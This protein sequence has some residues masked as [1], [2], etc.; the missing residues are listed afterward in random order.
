MSPTLNGSLD[1]Q[2]FER[3]DAIEICNGIIF[4]FYTRL[5]LWATCTNVNPLHHLPVIIL[6]SVVMERPYWKNWQVL[7]ELREIT[8]EDV[9]THATTDLFSDATVLCFAHGNLNESQVS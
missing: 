7:A 3:S 4:N 1:I 6:C 9:I 5:S 2:Y 8:I